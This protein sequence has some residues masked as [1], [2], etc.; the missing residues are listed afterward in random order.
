MTFGST[1]IT[2]VLSFILLLSFDQLDKL[3]DL[4]GILRS[5][6]LDSS[7]NIDR[8]RLDL[9]NPRR[10]IILVEPSRKDDRQPP[11]SLSIFVS[12][13]GIEWYPGL[14]ASFRAASDS[15]PA[16]TLASTWNALIRGTPTRRAHSIGSSPWS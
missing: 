3:P 13:N 6:R 1:G 5:I 11:L 2:R 10:K 7:T 8:P 9:L 12:N 16:T 14:A 4:L 15:P